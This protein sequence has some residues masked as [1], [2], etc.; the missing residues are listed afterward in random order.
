MTAADR[1][2]STPPGEVLI[3]SFIKGLGTTQNR[4]AVSIS[5]RPRRINEIVHGKCGIPADTALRL[6]T[7][8]GASAE[9]W[10]NLQS[11][12]ELGCGHDVADAQAQVAAVKPLKVA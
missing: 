1:I 12:C 11:C 10:T 8:F 6:A 7:Y 2:E 9:F 5:V 4:L 3:E